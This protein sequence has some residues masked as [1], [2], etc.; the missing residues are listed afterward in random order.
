MLSSSSV[1][2]EPGTFIALVLTTIQRGG[3]ISLKT[4]TWK[5]NFE[6]NINIHV[7]ESGLL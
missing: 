5:T 7:K 3:D 4:A 6:D 2:L 1:K